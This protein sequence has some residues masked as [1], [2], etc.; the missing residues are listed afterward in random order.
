MI[1]DPRARR[2]PHLANAP[3]ANSCAATRYDEK[4]WRAPFYVTG[5]EHFAY[6]WNGLRVG[7]NAMA[8][9]PVPREPR[10]GGL[11]AIAKPRVNSAAEHSDSVKIDR[12][13]HR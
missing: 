13:A 2:S 5:M 8:C 12:E 4:G 9:S 11:A 10:C 1:F 3:T 7:T 6:E